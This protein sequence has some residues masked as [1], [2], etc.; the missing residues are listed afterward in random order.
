MADT[1]GLKVQCFVGDSYL[2]IDG[3]KATLTPALMERV[4]KVK[5][6]HLPQIH[7]GSLE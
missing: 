1:G 6:L 3:I 2:P 7:Q 4:E 5:K